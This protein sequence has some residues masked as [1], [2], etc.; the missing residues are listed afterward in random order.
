MIEITRDVGGQ[1]SFALRTSFL[2]SF[3]DHTSTEYSD[4]VCLGWR[5]H[6]EPT[7]PVTINWW[8]LPL[9]A[10]QFTATTCMKT[11][12]SGHLPRFTETLNDSE[13]PVFQHKVSFTLCLSYYTRT[14][15]LTAIGSPRTAS[16]LEFRR[17]S[18]CYFQ[19]IQ[20]SS[21]KTKASLSI[22]EKPWK[23][24]RRTVVEPR[25]P[26]MNQALFSSCAHSFNI[27]ARDDHVLL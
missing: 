20:V 24:R 26:R 23:N 25:E 3:A 9:L 16:I 2:L 11:G 15:V 4:F 12:P 19:S 14:G 22:R 18:L 17:F 8:Y 21:A 7:P 13:T 10:L 1:T 5:D 27:A 6:K